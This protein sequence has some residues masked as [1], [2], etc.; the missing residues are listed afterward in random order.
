MQS[1]A[2]FNG[3]GKIAKGATKSNAEQESRVLMLSEKARGDANP[4]LLNR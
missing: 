3:I 2:I 4:I 1:T